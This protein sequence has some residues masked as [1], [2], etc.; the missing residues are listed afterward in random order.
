MIR[1]DS[2]F[3]R[4]DLMTWCEDNGVQYVLGLAGNERLVAKIK[5]ELKAAERK[6]KRSG[7]ESRRACSP[8]SRIARAR[9]GPASAG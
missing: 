9:A 4:D 3:C 2:G 6:A 5:P 7:E 1:A 8:S